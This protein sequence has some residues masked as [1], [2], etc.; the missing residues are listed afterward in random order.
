MIEMLG[1]RPFVGK[2][3]DMDKWLDEHGGERPKAAFPA[4]EPDAPLPSPSV[5]S[6]TVD[7]HL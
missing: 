1:K 4:P 7:K 5:A 6:R 2:A 3:D